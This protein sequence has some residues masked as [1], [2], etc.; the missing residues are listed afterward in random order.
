MSSTLEFGTQL[1]G[2][3][4]KTLNAIL[5]RLLAGTDITE[6]QWVT[7]TVAVMSGG[8]VPAAQFASR[9]A[10]ALKVGGD[11]ARTRIDEL[12]NAQLIELRQTDEEEASVTD[13]GRELHADIRGQVT[14]ITQRLWG[15]L[16]A[17]DL[18]TAGRVLS[19]VLERANAE[20]ARI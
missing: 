14:E 12:A 17:D 18:A 19:T 2:Q 15:D 3:T 6:P 10:G 9:V 20:L 1:I 16:S 5:G 11:D 4:E 7:L 13:A 8:S